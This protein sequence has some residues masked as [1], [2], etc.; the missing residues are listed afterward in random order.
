MI[1]LPRL[2]LETKGAG[3][4]GNG[5]FDLVRRAGGKLGIDFEGDVQRGVGVA[6]EEGD[7]LF[8]DLD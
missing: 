8:G 6:G 7:D 1:L 4:F 5:T 3:V 2:R